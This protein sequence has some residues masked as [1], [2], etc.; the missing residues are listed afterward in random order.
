MKSFVILL[1]DSEDDN[2]QIKKTLVA[3]KLLSENGISYE[4]V[5]LEGK[6]RIGKI[7]SNYLLSDWT[8]YYLALNR[9][10]DP[11]ETE[12]IEKFKKMER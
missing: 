1:S 12:M 5:K 8:S 3:A 10:V 7:F 4:I 11:T 2:R 9:K 6:T